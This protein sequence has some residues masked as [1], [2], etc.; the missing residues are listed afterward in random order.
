MFQQKRPN[1]KKTNSSQQKS[2]DQFTYENTFSVQSKLKKLKQPTN[3]SATE[4][5]ESVKKYLLTTKV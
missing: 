4:T 2:P 3:I 5:R 1:S